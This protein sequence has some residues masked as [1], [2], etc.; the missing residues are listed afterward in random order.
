MVPP[1]E[2]QHFSWAAGQQSNNS[3]NDS[4]NNY[5]RFNRRRVPV[6]DNQVYVFTATSVKETGRHAV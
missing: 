6:N 1:L 2:G 5:L 4:Q 3:Q